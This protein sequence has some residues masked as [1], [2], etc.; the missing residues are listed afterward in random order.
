M[1]KKKQTEKD[2]ETEI[3][4]VGDEVNTEEPEIEVVE[5]KNEEENAGV[6]PEDGIEELKRKL[7]EERLARSE[8]EKRAKEAQAAANKAA[9]ETGEHRISLV[10]NALDNL[11]RE[12]DILKANIK[13]LMVVGDYDRAIELQEAFQ[14]NISKMVQLQNGLD[15]MKREPVRRVEQPQNDGPTVDDLI[16]RV[17]P[18]S[19]QWLERN[20]SHI[21][22]SRTIRI[23]A[24]AHEDAIDHGIIPESDAYFGF[25]ENRLGL[26]KAQPR[27]EPRYEEHEPVMSAASAPTQRRSAPAAA[28]VSRSGT[29]GS[30]NPRTIRLTAE[31]AEAAKISGLT[32]KEYWDLL[33]DER[34]R[35]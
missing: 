28:P 27:Q 30:G 19:A 7:E 16:Q 20:R 18:R 22:D 24:R 23:M 29:G 6:A 17:T 33:Q 8:A 26:N 9:T 35:N 34:N 14:L 12:Q 15:E 1:P 31:Q 3:E 4:I 2:L 25:L 32:N 11:K 13:E 21:Q 5:A 10:S